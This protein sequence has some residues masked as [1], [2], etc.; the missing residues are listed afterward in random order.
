MRKEFTEQVKQVKSLLYTRT[1]GEIVNINDFKDFVEI[2]EHDI[3]AQI[4][5]HNYS[6]EFSY[7]GCFLYPCDKNDPRYEFRFINKT[8]L[9]N[10]LLKLGSKQ[11]LQFKTMLKAPVSDDYNNVDFVF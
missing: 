3:R 8:D 9:D 6:V 7:D 1:N 2:W 10:Q 5:F 11:W 4:G